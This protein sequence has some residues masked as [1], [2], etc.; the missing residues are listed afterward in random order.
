MEVSSL[1][2]VFFAFFIL[3]TSFS[4]SLPRFSL[5][6]AARDR[7]VEVTYKGLN[8]TEDGVILLTSKEPKDCRFNSKWSC[9]NGSLEVLYN[10]H[11]DPSKSY[12]KTN[13][14]F[15]YTNGSE[16]NKHS[17]CHSVWALYMN[18]S[19]RVIASTCIMA[20]PTW[21]NDLLPNVGHRRFRDLIIPG[22]HDS[23]SYKE[24]FDLPQIELPLTRYALTQD[25]T[26]LGQLYQG[27]RYLDIRPAYYKNLQHKWYVNH[28]VTIQQTLDHVM[29]Q[30]IT[31]VNETR[32]PV[33]FGLKEFPIGFANSDV[34]RD[35]VRYMQ[36]YFGNFTLKPLSDNPWKYFLN[37]LLS[38]SEGRIILAYDDRMIVEEFPDILFPAVKQNW[39]D[40]RKWNALEQYLRVV[41]LQDPL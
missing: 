18:S 13:V 33:I 25:D 5:T 12:E 17:R 29:D 37:E 15:K 24:G 35:L 7:K 31:F 14:T 10:F 27:A 30:V 36:F 34:H 19:G 6:V 21:I 23:A 11:P 20:Y 22:T 40:V 16:F 32:E 1:I 3:P 2:A 9:N 41:S 8:F 4:E 39:G 28:G 26:I 38:S